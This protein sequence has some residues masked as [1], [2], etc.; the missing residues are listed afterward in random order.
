MR[1]V[2]LLA[3]PVLTALLAATSAAHIQS[4]MVKYTLA[5]EVTSVTRGE[6][7]MLTLR[8]ATGG[9]ETKPPKPLP[10]AFAGQTLRIRITA[11]TRIFRPGS[12][13][14]KATVIKKG[15]L[16]VITASAP[17]RATPKTTFTALKITFA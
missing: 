8:L 10:A 15:H 17:D 6:A 13:I 12:G 4:G 3:V 7:T 16:L 9:T 11:A 5:G 1:K 14:V 2:L